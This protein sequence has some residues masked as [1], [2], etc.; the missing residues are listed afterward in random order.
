MHLFHI[1][2]DATAILRSKGVY[3]QVTV[4]RRGDEVFA[5]WG[6]G[7]VKLLSAGHTTHPNVSWVDVDPAGVTI[8][9][10]PGGIRIKEP[11]ASPAPSRRAA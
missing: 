4:Y 3:R 9:T 11:A 10:T 2:D 8:Q 1:I 6:A 5:K 7:Y